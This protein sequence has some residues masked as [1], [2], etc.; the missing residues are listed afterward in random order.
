[1]S[2]IVY[3]IWQATSEQ[4]QNGFYDKSKPYLNLSSARKDYVKVKNDF[5]SLD[6]TWEHLEYNRWE[7]DK[8]ERIE[9]Q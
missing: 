9:T 6:K 8:E 2:R 7:F 1:M 4:N 3:Y 5:K